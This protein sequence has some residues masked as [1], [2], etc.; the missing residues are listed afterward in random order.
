M[1]AYLLCAGF[2]TRMRPLTNETPKS[3]LSI[4]GRPLLDH[5]IGELRDWAA[6]DAIHLAVN[7]RDAEAFHEWADGWDA[8]LAANDVTL[9]VH[10]DGV[11]TTAEQLGAVG[12]LRFL[13]EETGV[14]P[15]GALVSGG[16]S[17]YRF[18]LPPLLNAFHGTTTR[19]LALH[20]PSREQRRQSSIL[21]LT[22]S[23]VT[24]LIET[25]ETP[26]ERICPSFHLLP[27]EA[28]STIPSYLEAGHDPDTLGTFIHSLAQEHRVEAVRLPKRKHLRLHC[29]TPQDLEQARTLLAQNPRYVLDAETVRQC[30]PERGG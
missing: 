8:P 14:P 27:P 25:D 7:H 17:L 6:L 29:N 12:D 16:D 18:P 4:A 1:V 2:G 15:D 9:Q 5:L 10:D 21:Q 19:V 28:L 13:L 20:E 24:G 11:S 3:L 26:S 23:R 30:L 22:G